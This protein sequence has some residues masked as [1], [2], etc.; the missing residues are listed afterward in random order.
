MIENKELAEFKISNVNIKDLNLKN[1][2]K[3]GGDYDSSSLYLALNQVDIN[4][5]ILL[6]Y[7]ELA[8]D[9]KSTIIFVSTL[10]IVVKYVGYFNNK[11]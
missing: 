10:S 1:V 3:K 5:K 2:P 6:A 7:M 8:K 4:E 11:E 9:Y